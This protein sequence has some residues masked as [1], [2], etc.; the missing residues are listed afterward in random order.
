MTNN[1]VVKAEAKPASGPFDPHDNDAANGLFMLA[2]GRNGA[3]STNQF[4]VTGAT[5]HAHPAPVQNMDTSPQI[6][7]ANGAS[8]GSARGVSEGSASEESEQATR[9]NTRGKGKKVPPPT[10]G[11]RRAD[12]APKAPPSKK[13][14]AV[15]APADENIDFSDDEM[16]DDMGTKSKMTDEEK[17]KNFLERNRY[18]IFMTSLCKLTCLGW[19]HSNV[20]SA[21]SNG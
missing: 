21:K 14:K 4:A 19:L 9:P 16:K 3:Q 7:N 18:V 2:Q 1:V 20:A 5:T 8:G 11:R 15:S 13:A 17:R 6:S 10:N 12:D